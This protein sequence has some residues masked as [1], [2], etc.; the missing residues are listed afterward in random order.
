M[1]VESCGGSDLLQRAGWQAP[2]AADRLNEAESDFS[3]QAGVVGEEDVLARPSAEQ[4]LHLVALGDAY[5]NQLSRPPTSI[6]KLF[7]DRL[8]G[9]AK[10]DTR[11][12]ARSRRTVE[13]VRARRWRCRRS[14]SPCR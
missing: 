13:G 3:I 1:F 4:S 14:V 2:D 6:P 7:H 12:R 9:K 11:S 8:V 10:T 5:A